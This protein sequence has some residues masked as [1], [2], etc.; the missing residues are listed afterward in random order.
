MLLGGLW[1]G[2]NLRFVLWGFYHG[3]ILLLEKLFK[4]ES[5]ESIF[6]PKWRKFLSR[7]L[8]FHLILL[9]WLIFRAETPGTAW[10]MLKQVFVNFEA[11]TVFQFMQADVMIFLLLIGSFVFISLPGRLNE[12][13]RGWFIVR[14]YWLKILMVLIALFLIYEFQI[15][16]LKPFIYFRF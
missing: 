9:G 4:R 13:F 8:T 2:A 6:K 15:S 1:H 14:P 12:S 7:F 10:L 5:K 16:E 3:V 11:G